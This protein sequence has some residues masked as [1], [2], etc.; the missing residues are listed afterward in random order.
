MLRYRSSRALHKITTRA[1]NSTGI[2]AS[3]EK[4]SLVQGAS[5]GNNNPDQ[6]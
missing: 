2:N 1:I 5:R 4:V 6:T 3:S